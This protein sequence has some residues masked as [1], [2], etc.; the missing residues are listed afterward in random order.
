[1]VKNHLQYANRLTELGGTLYFSAIKDRHTW[2]WKS[3]GTAVGTMGVTEAH[4]HLLTEF[5]QNLYFAGPVCSRGHELWKSDGTAHG[6]V[7]V[8][9]VNRSGN[10]GSA[11]K[12][13]TSG[14]DALFF[15]A[16]DDIHGRELWKSDGTKAGTVMVRDI[17]P[18]SRGIAP[19][20]FSLFVPS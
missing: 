5:K 14:G 16:S 3:D 15:T 9:V 7:R 11:L 10:C 17:N 4:I 18:G 12:L 8:K 13:L 20:R 6:T 1:M 19:L 2:L